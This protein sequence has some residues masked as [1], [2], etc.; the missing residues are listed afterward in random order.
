MKKVKKH[1]G[2]L[3]QSLWTSLAAPFIYIIYIFYYVKIP[4][5]ENSTVPFQ[6]L[7]SKLNRWSLLRLQFSKH[8]S[9]SHSPFFSQIFHTK[10]AILK[11]F[12]WML[13]DWGSKPLQLPPH[14]FT[15]TSSFGAKHDI[16]KPLP[17]YLPTVPLELHSKLVLSRH[18][19][20]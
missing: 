17:N 1:S 12:S 5:W 9:S 19:S 2:I 7:L 4:L 16:G 3:F 20:W 8:F 11:P 6:S 13:Q 14:F 18:Q 15:P 10:A